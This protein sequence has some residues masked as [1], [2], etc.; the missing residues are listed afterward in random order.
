[1]TDKIKKGELGEQLA[2]NFLTE[3]GYDILERNYRYK[4]SEI[5]LIVKKDNWLVFVE[6]K[7]RTSETFGYPENFVD[8]KKAEK[9]LEGAEQYLFET[10]WDGNVRYDIISIMLKKD[11]PEVVHFEDAFH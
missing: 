3:K 10:N 11:I 7:T 6:V 2:A 1:M 4:H 5:D 9:I 8:D